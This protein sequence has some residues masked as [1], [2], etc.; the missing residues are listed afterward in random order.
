MLDIANER[1]SRPTKADSRL[2]S[3]SRS[4]SPSKTSQDADA[5]DVAE[6]LSDAPVSPKPPPQRPQSRPLSAATTN[7]AST[8]TPSNVTPRKRP[9]SRIPIPPVKEEPAPAPLKQPHGATKTLHIFGIP[10][11]SPRKSSFGSRPT[12]PLEVPKDQTVAASPTSTPKAK[13]KSKVGKAKPSGEESTPTP[14]SRLDNLSKFFVG[15]GIRVSSAPERPKPTRS[16]SKP[17]NAASSNLPTLKHSP[18]SLKPSGSSSTGQTASKSAFKQPS[19]RHM[20][21][22][23][24]IARVQE[25]VSPTPVKRSPNSSTGTFGANTTHTRVSGASALGTTSALPIRSSISNPRPST[26]PRASGTGLSLSVATPRARALSTGAGESRPATGISTRTSA[27]T[28]STTSSVSTRERRVSTDSSYAHRV[29]RPTGRLD[30]IEEDGLKSALIDR[31]SHVTTKSAAIATP[32]MTLPAP[33]ATATKSSLRSASNRKHGSFDFERPGWGSLAARGTP[34]PR[35]LPERGVSGSLDGHLDRGTGAGLAG[36]GAA[37]FYAPTSAAHRD[38]RVIPPPTPPEL[39]PNHT[40]ASASTSAS[41][42]NV[43]GGTSSWGR[44]AGKR[45]SAGLSKLTNGLGLGGKST[46][47][48]LN[49]KERQHGKFSFEPPVPTLPF[50]IRRELSRESDQEEKDRRVARP[51]SAGHNPSHSTSSTASSTHTGLSAGHRA[52]TK[53]RSLDLGLGLSWAPTKLREDAVMPD[54]S[55][56]RTLSASR[57]ERRGKEVAEEFREALDEE[58]Y[59]SFK[60][61]VHRFDAHEIPFDGRTGIVTRVERL[62]RRAH[63]LKEEER[64]R[65]LDSFVKLTLQAA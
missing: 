52:G 24:N 33:S 6:L 38:V 64:D 3:P 36:V 5:A 27:T 14:P 62:L 30:G 46:K 9:P 17:S 57:R 44:N 42:S 48:T 22:V 65:L 50:S 4:R 61:Y 10:L 54:S 31:G 20:S 58:G 63:H 40:G 26:S 55:L 16:S 23:G 45:L 7:T 47:S 43:T 8:V 35:R 39:E 13:V 18:V 21:E 37:R 60:K 11:S 15:T 1:S 28:L 12:T 19:R 53:G 41:H 56:G 32:T 51:M 34:R 59:R 25:P 49:I 29:Y 2:V